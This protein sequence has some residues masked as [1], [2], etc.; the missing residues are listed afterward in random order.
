MPSWI[1]SRFACSTGAKP[2]SPYCESDRGTR[3]TAAP[4]SAMAF[5]IS[6]LEPEQWLQCVRDVREV[7]VA[8]PEEILGKLVV[9]VTGLSGAGDVDGTDTGAEQRLDGGIRMLATS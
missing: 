9:V 1:P 6:S 7:L 2:P 8:Q 3:F 5:H 4:L